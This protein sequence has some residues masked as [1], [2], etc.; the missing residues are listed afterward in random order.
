MKFYNLY[1]SETFGKNDNRKKLFS[2]LKE[3][4]KKQKTSIIVSKNF[5]INVLNVADIISAV[6]ILLKKI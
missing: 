2:T 4:Y 5:K 6:N 1:L 3:N